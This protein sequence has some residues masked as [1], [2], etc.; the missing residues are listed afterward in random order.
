M[1]KYDDLME[2]HRRL[3]GLWEATEQLDVISGGEYTGKKVH[4]FMKFDNTESG[5]LILEESPSELVFKAPLSVTFSE[6]SLII[7]Q[8]GRAENEN[9]DTSYLQYDFSC[10]SDKD[11]YLWCSA[12]ESD[13]HEEGPSF[14]L[15]KVN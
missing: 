2:D 11:G 15:R 9:S 10:I 7:R 6:N 4:L 5:T 8:Q 12:E 3:I 14:N 13:S 1:L